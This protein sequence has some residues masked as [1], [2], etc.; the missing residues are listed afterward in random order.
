MEGSR[1]LPARCSCSPRVHGGGFSC[2]LRTYRAPA[3]TTRLAVL[4]VGTR[5]GIG[6]A[7]E[8]VLDRESIQSGAVR[9]PFFATPR[10]P[11]IR[12]V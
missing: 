1:C 10:T 8:E 2:L 5:H 7:V 3:T 11:V 12:R 4:P 6:V 9:L